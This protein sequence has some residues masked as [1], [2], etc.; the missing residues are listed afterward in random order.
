MSSTLVP[1]TL[2]DGRYRLRSLLGAGG[3]GR[4]YAAEDLQLGR[5]VAIKVLRDA[6]PDAVLSE[7]LFREAKAAARAQHPAVVTVYGYGVDP[8]LGLSYVAMEHLV[9]ET[10]SDRLV[11]HGPMPAAE[12]VRTGIEIAEA[13]VAVH[14]T[15]V[16]HRDIKPSNV[17]VL[18]PMRRGPLL[19]LL[20]FGVAKQLDMQTLTTTGQ[21]FGTLAYMAPEQLRDS[22]RIDERCDI[23]ALGVLLFECATG[24][25]PFQ[26]VPPLELATRILFGPTPSLEG[27]CP[28]LHDSLVAIIEC[29][30]QRDRF[31]RFANAGA[32]LHAL[33]T[34]ERG[35]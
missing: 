12:L 29:C 27:L 34:I 24:R 22:K 16:V 2:L 32:V 3:M 14:G 6:D 28:E 1:G 31:E 18:E 20:D 19:K 11:R 13:L 30:M 23:Y 5:R 10:L 26:D 33:G 8:E 7:R 17:F 21:V 4:V 9:G 15:G 25:S 35:G